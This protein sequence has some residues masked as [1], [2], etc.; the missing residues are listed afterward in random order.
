MRLRAEVVRRRIGD[1]RRPHPLPSS[2]CIVA[3]GGPEYGAEAR[4][5]RPRDFRAGPYVAPA[6]AELIGQSGD[7]LR[8]GHILV[9]HL[10]RGAIPVTV[11]L[12]KY[13]FRVR[14]AG[15]PLVTASSKQAGK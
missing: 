3:F 7:H 9:E 2:R 10:D 11:N 15:A 14:S 5:K 4:Q 6:L 8:V 12:A 1:Q 13:R